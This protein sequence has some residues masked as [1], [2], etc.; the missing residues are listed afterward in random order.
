MNRLLTTIKKIQD[1][2]A[3][4]RKIQGGIR[5]EELDEDLQSTLLS[6]NKMLTNLES[7]FDQLTHTEY[8]DVCEY[9]FFGYEPDRQPFIASLT[10]ALS[11]FQESITVFFDALKS[12]AKDRASYDVETAR[13]SS[14]SLAYNFS[15]SIGFMMTMPNER[16]LA[17]ESK[18][19]QAMRLIFEISKA[20]TP[21]Q[22]AA[23]VPK[24]GRA[25]IRRIYNWAKD[26]ADSSLSAE[27]KWKRGGEVRDQLFIQAPEL[28]HLTKVIDKVSDEQVEQFTNN[29]KLVGFDSKAKTF[30]LELEKG[31]PDIK[32]SLAQEFRSRG[33]ITVDARYEATIKKITTMR[34]STEKEDISYYLLYLDNA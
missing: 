18:L 3:A 14:F 34:Y 21:E 2:Q 4:I 10:R 22:V 28:D 8:L 25:A 27:I 9:R 5:L 11:D 6:L 29:A 23:F 15:G 12:G 20:E 26:H 19:D 13:E 16:L 33:E 1:T 31:I 30:H 7:E 17:V 24:V 32:G